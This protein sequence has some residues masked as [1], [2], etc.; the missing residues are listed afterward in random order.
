VK[1]AVLQQTFS[2]LLGIFPIF[3]IIVFFFA[4]PL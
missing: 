4:H 3:S 2:L 1:T